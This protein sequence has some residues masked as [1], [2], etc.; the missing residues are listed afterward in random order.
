M[1]DNRYSVY[2]FAGKGVFSNVM[3]A[4]DVSNNDKQ[5]AIKIIRNNDLM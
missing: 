5:V 4:R 3:R 2:A 1:M